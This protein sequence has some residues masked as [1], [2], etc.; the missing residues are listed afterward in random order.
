V[1]GVVNIAFGTIAGGVFGAV[2]S[3]FSR[4]KPPKLEVIKPEVEA[5]IIKTAHNQAVAGRKVNIGK[6]FSTGS[7]FFSSLFSLTPSGSVC[8]AFISSIISSI[9]RISLSIV[10]EETSQQA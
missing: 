8:F 7:N 6:I 2:G 10:I 5:R 1:G 3:A 4:V 9:I